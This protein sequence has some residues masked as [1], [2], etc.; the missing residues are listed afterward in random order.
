MKNLKIK[1]LFEQLPI[2]KIMLNNFLIFQ[3]YT[4]TY[5]RLL[6]I[7]EYYRRLMNENEKKSLEN[8]FDKNN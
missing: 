6:I 2:E 8:V 3:N 1:E 7:V 4:N 5:Y